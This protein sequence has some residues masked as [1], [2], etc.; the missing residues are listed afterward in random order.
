MLTAG[1]LRKLAPK[2]DG[3]TRLD[4]WSA[5]AEPEGAGGHF[6]LAG[7]R[8]GLQRGSRGGLVSSSSLLASRFG[9]STRAAGGHC[10]DWE[11]VPLISPPRGTGRRER[12]PVGHALPRRR[13]AGHTPPGEHLAPPGSPSSFPGRLGAPAPGSGSG[14]RDCAWRAA[15]REAPRHFLPS[16]RTLPPPVKPGC[17]YAPRSPQQPPEGKGAD[18]P[19]HSVCPTPYTASA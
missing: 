1:L 6:V 4:F 8:R 10:G 18:R 17:G 3:I 14:S 15:A 5:A 2:G 16:Q 13:P 7:E 9:P 11:G 19:P 12:R